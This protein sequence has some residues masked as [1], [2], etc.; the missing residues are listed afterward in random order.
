MKDSKTACSRYILPEKMPRKHILNMLK[1]C[2]TIKSTD[3]VNEKVAL[4]DSFEWG[5]YEN[6]LIAFRLE[7]NDIKIWH[8]D[9]LFDL[10]QVL[11]IQNDNPQTKFWWDFKATP[12]R[13]LMEKI[14]DLRAL[15]TMSEGV[16]K[17]ENYNLQDDN[18]KTLVF[19]QLIAFYRTTSARIPLLRQ[20]SLTQVT[21]YN[22]EYMQA[23]QL[24][25]ELGGFTPSLN[26]VDSL[27]G[28]IGVT[29]DP[30]TV[31]PDLAI[32]ASM[33]A[34]VAANSIISQLLEKQRLTE[35]G[36]I[37]DIDTEFLHHF[38]VS[39]RMTRAAIVQLKEVYPEQDLLMLK[40]RFGKLGRETNHLRDLDVFIL[41]KPRYLNL[42][43]DSLSA[44]LLPMFDDFETDRVNE[45][46][47]I[48]KWLSSA[49]YKKEI[50][51][52][53]TLFEKGYPACETQWSERPVVELA[54]SKIMKRFKKIQKAALKISN[55]TPDEAI[56]SIRIDCKKLRY[57]LYFFNGLF[58]KKQLKL[59]AQQL[60]RLQDKLGI[61]NDLT[62][63]GKYLETYLDQIEH[64]QKIDIFLI[65]ALGGL[66]AVLHRMQKRERDNCINELHVFSDEKNLQIFTRVF[67]AK[68]LEE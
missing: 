20:V 11:L 67:V 53:Q 2:F 43:P 8:T 65:A 33:P 44:G 14:L 54:T 62:V 17:I 56:H 63:Q 6:D 4:V 25:E 49:A 34:R 18:G 61:F 51:E 1:K 46:K 58:D 12:E 59:A 37:D 13:T 7:N 5:F 35:Q 60:K 68:G 48:A 27:L 19:F 10:D 50:L 57:L 41:D 31:K 39:L 30:Y 22:K 23:R 21:G 42:L 66:I 9:E 26:P 28:A 32:E 47:R 36:V 40:E 3:S 45:V 64:K 24:L 29:P 15:L 55:D 52:L 38:R 16:V